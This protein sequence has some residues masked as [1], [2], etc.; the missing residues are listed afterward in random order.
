MW[1]SAPCILERCSHPR[2]LDVFRVN[3][4]KVSDLGIVRFLSVLIVDWAS[5]E[6]KRAVQWIPLYSRTCS[7]GLCFRNCP[8]VIKTIKAFQDGLSRPSGDHTW[9]VWQ[10]LETELRENQHFIDITSFVPGPLHI[11]DNLY[12]CPRDYIIFPFYKWGK[13]GW[14]TT[15][16][17]G[18]LNP[19]PVPSDSEQLSHRALLPQEEKRRKDTWAPFYRIPPNS[20]KYKTRGRVSPTKRHENVKKLGQTRC[21]C[22]HPPWAFWDGKP[23]GDCCHFF[24][25]ST[26]FGLPLH[27][28]RC[29]LFIHLTNIDWSTSSYWM[30]TELRQTWFLPW[31]G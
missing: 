6:R 22:G 26:C 29:R 18:S 15:R 19:N 23:V 3:V 2:H 11:W 28:N 12:G 7:F 30:K 25:V 24:S 14:V 16:K 21:P 17:W 4:L 10:H 5:L 8:V 31:W 20:F 1:T 27:P 9:C 13:T